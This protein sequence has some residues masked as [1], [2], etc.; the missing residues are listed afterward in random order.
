MPEPSVADTPLRRVLST[1]TLLLF[2][3]GD[4]LGAGIYALVGEVGAEVGGAIWT[5]FT[6][7]FVLA[8]LTVS[9]VPLRV[10][11]S[12]SP[13][14]KNN[15]KMFRRSCRGIPAPLSSIRTAIRWGPSGRV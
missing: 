12:S 14:R 15:R 2:V 5:A 9:S 1:R 11:F 13:P 8:L 7:A 4:V 3:V 6:A 10:R